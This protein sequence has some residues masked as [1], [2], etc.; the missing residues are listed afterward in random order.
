[1]C[2]IIGIIIGSS[3]PVLFRS[4]RSLCLRLGDI[5]LSL[6]P[7]HQKIAR[8]KE[9]L[10]S[11]TNYAK[12]GAF[13]QQTLTHICLIHDPENPLFKNQ[14]IYNKRHRLWQQNLDGLTHIQAL[15]RTLFQDAQ[16]FVRYYPY[17]G[18]IERRFFAGKL[19]ERILKVS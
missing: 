11:I 4:V 12:T 2:L 8:T 10:E 7:T 17:S 19:S 9:V 18:P 3:L 6:H 16:W 15:I 13:P 5:T 1:M 14:D